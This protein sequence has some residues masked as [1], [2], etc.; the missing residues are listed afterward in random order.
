MPSLPRTTMYMFISQNTPNA[1][2][3]PPGTPSQVGQTVRS[4][5]SIACPPIQV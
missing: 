1:I 4:M 5:V 3:G 2:H